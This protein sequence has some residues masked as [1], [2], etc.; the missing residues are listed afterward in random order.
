MK[1]I[2]AC[3]LSVNGLT[4][5]EDE[6][7]LLS[8][9]NPLGVTLFKRNISDKEQVKALTNSIKSV[10]GR[11][12]VLIAVDQEGGRVCR[13]SEPNWKKYLSQHALGSI[14]ENQQEEFIRLHGALI[15][16]DLKELGVN[17]NFAPVLDV[18]YSDTTDALR[19]RIF[20]GDEKQVAL[21]G[22]T[23][24]DAYQQNG[25]CPCVKH[26]PGHGRAVVDPHLH[27]PI[28]MQ[29]LKELEKDFYP[30]QFVANEAVAGMTAHI[31]ISDIDEKPVT[32]S[33]KAI[34]EI[35][36]KRIGFDGFLFSDAIDMKALA[37]SLTERVQ[38]CLSAGCDAVCYCFG[39]L[40]E[41]KQVVDAC[42][43]LSDLAYERFSK[44]RKIIEKPVLTLDIKTAYER[45]LKLGLKARELVCD[46]DAVEILH[47]IK[48]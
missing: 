24:L 36:R 43:E 28:I 6:K 45:Y 30:F 39:V 37:G 44:I 31:V 15:A 5:T 9:A 7:S 47:Q 18:S 19:S 35:I 13:F 20:S 3:M 48:K 26:L 16:H 4:L 32:L 17:L 8:K 29:S 25:I 42:F 1:P 34:D 41:M 12:D 33:K 2:L 10:I 27:L 14:S 40:D 38:G 23:L 22:K 21:N 46:Y 11:E